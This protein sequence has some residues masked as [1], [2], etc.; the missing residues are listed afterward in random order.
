MYGRRGYRK[1]GGSFLDNV[2]GSAVL[3]LVA[4]NVI[5][6]ILQ[7]VLIRTRFGDVFGLTPWLVVHRGWI[8]QV[9]TYMF[10]HG[11]FFHLA[12]NMFIIYMFGRQ[13]EAVWGNARFLRYY[14]LC[15]LGAA[16]ASF[17]FS[18]RTTVIG[19]SGAGYGILLAYAVLFPYNE[20]YVW[21]LFPVRAR[22]FVIV[23]AGIEFLNGIT[24]GDGIAHFA[25][26]GGMAA[27][28]LVLRG[29]HRSFRL[30]NRL[31]RL[32]RR[33]PISVRFGDESPP[34]GAAND[35]AAKVDSI[36]DKISE[37]GWENLTETE[38]RI[39]ERYSDEHRP[40]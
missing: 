34:D 14:L 32:W 8:W 11:G 31:G 30:W 22:T 35:D 17:L 18:Y 16:A 33:I 7:I 37:K 10:L 2:T 5:V 23:I 15:G 26:L 28:L 27:G 19:A 38:R 3:T 4:I 21:G 39:L 9:V 25:H 13:L 12:L 1:P 36:L 24:G 29:D 40:R 6:F 20:I